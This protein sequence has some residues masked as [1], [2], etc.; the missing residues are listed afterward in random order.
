MILTTRSIASTFT[1][2]TPLNEWRFFRP[3]LP[4][5]NR[6]RRQ[7]FVDAAR[8]VDGVALNIVDADFP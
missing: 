3:H 2:K 6:L 5:L 7:D 1:K 4:Y 8:L